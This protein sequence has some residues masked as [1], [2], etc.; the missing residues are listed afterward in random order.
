M[1]NLAYRRAMKARMKQRAKRKMPTWS[2]A[3]QHADHLKACSCYMCGNPRRY[4]KGIEKITMQER[5]ANEAT[6]NQIR[7]ILYD[8]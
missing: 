5:K 2:N 3:E 8:E 7:E 1:R 6:R 4:F